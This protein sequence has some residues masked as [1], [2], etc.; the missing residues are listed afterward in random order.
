MK[1]VLALLLAIIIT[2]SV[3]AQIENTPKNKPTAGKLFG[4]IVD[5]K[6]NKGIDAASV[7]LF[8]K[9]NGTLAGGMLTKPNGDFDIS[10]LAVTDTFR[11]EATAIGY[12]KQEIIITL[13][14]SGKGSA[15]TAEKTL[16]ISS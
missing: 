4:R 1:P 14:K 13:D 8:Q 3:C 16:A 2:L 6:T 15:T 11:L 12:A 9:N 5:A 10:N 7:Q